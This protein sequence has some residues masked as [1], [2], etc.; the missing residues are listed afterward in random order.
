MWIHLSALNSAFGLTPDHPLITDEDYVINRAI[1]KPDL[2][3]STFM[4]TADAK[5]IYF[6]LKNYKVKFRSSIVS[7]FNWQRRT[8]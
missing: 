8:L 3:V 1:R 6:F 5:E 7:P 4:A 2:K